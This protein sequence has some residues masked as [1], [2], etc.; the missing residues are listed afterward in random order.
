MKI[1]DP[2]TRRAESGFTLLE[3]MIAVVIMGVGLLT[4]G[5][6]QLTAM[7]IS[8]ESRQM[9]QAMY[10]AEQQMSAFLLVTPPAAGTFQDP[11]NPFELSANDDDLPTFERSWVVQTDTPQPGLAT[12]AIQVI[13]NNPQ[14]NAA[15][16][17]RR[18]VTL[19][20]IV[21]P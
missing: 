21:G 17:G 11:G 14:A 4:I 16:A 5:L 7:R 3:V 9:T 13:W 20:G 8:T 18:N 10:L 19:R 12:V 6:A 15:N 1:A 2:R